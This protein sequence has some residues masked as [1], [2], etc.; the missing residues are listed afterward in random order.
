MRSRHVRWGMLLAVLSCTLLA[1]PAAP[2]TAATTCKDYNEYRGVT[3]SLLDVRICAAPAS[4]FR[5]HAG[6]GRILDNRSL[7]SICGAFMMLP[8]DIDEPQPRCPVRMPEPVISWTWSG[9]AWTSEL[10]TSLAPGARV[11]VYPYAAGWRWVWTK[12]TG[13]RVMD[14][15]DLGFRWRA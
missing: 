3:P 13:W 12:E 5:G 4:D 8:L 10:L 7:G 14:E 15:R 2:A 1:L 6:W 9:T 11:Y